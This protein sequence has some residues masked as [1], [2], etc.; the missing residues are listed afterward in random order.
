MNDWHLYLDAFPFLFEGGE[1]VDGLRVAIVV[2]PTTGAHPVVV[3]SGANGTDS[4]LD[5][6]GL[7]V[8]LASLLQAAYM[9]AASRHPQG[10]QFAKYLVTYQTQWAAAQQL[11]APTQQQGS[12]S[13]H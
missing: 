12:G 8:A 9:W 11:A 7:E 10:W 3:C 5:M 4:V 6:P 1:G 13:L 2:C